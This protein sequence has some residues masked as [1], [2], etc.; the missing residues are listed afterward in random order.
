MAQ[1]KKIAAAISAVISYINM[2]EQ[3]LELPQSVTSP[4]QKPSP[5]ASAWQMDGRQTTMQIR[6]L[7]QMKGFHGTKTY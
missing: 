2:E 7:M 1:K 3:Y 4:I 5:Q 6:N